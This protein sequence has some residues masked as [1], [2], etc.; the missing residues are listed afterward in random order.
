MTK[1]QAVEALDSSMRD[2]MGRRDVPFGGKTVVFGGDFQQVLPVVRKGMRPRITGTALCNSY[3]WECIRQLRLVRN[4]R[5][6]SDLEFTEFL[7][8]VGNGTEET[9]EDGCLWLP[10]EIC[11]PHTGKDI[12]LDKLIQSV[13]SMLD[14]NLSDPNYITSRAILLSRNEYVDRINMKMI[15][16]FRG[17]ELVYHNFNRVDGDPHSYYP[18]PLPLACEFLNTL[19]PNGLPSLVLKLKINCLVI[20]MQNID[21][22]NGLCNGMRLVVQGF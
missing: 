5:A 17:E 1:R 11:I 4:M 13:F 6:Q 14:E 18:R 16:L 21:P 7:L 22:A 20:L 3:L 10:D 8:R 12:D 9:N 19:T 15:N 2:I